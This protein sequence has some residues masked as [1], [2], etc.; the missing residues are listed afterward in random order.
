MTPETSADLIRD[1]VRIEREAQLREFDAIDAKAGIILGFAGAL[2]ALA[3]LNRNGIVDVGRILAAAG[4]LGAD[5]RF[6]AVHL[7]DTK[8][9]IFDNTRRLLIGKI[10]RLKAAMVTLAG[11][12]LLVGLGSLV[13]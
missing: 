10:Q 7:L 13:R 12:A 1:E 11:A 9:Q 2:A 5:V 4:A 3:P 8:I 6:T